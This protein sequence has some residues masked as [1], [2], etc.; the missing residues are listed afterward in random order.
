MQSPSINLTTLN[1]TSFLLSVYFIYVIQREHIIDILHMDRVWLFFFSTHR[2]HYC[3]FTARRQ[4]T[5]FGV[6]ILMYYI[7]KNHLR[8]Y[9]FAL[10][11]LVAVEYW[12]DGDGFILFYCRIKTNA[13]CF[14]N[15]FVFSAL[16]C[17]LTWLSIL[18]VINYKLVVHCSR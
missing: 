1:Q 14:E 15:F 7:N 17:E 18:L 5:W 9:L 8:I 13:S 2:F 12:L 11:S 16:G 4:N 6:W 10:G 3:S